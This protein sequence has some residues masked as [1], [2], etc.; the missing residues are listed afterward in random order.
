MTS[1]YL[2]RRD[3]QDICGRYSRTLAWALM[4]VLILQGTVA[5]HRWKCGS[6]GRGQLLVSWIGIDHFVCSYPGFETDIS[7]IELGLALTS[8]LLARHPSNSALYTFA[9]DT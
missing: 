1:R 7:G 2:P 5:K 3:S 6:D 9:C 4:P 8:L